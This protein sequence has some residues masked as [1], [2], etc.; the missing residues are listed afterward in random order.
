MK[1]EE[2]RKEAPVVKINE[3]LL[4]F[5]LAAIN[6]THIMDFVIMAPLG[7]LLKKEF[8]IDTRESSFLIA[9]YTLSA[10]VSGFLGTFVIDRF[11][12]RNVLLFMYAGF[13]I[14]NL[15]CAL[16]DSYHYFLIARIVAGV[17]GG[18]LGALV[19][20]IVG[21]AVPYER[22]GKATGIVMSAFSF[23]SVVGIPL[24]LFLAAK[25]QWRMPFV[26]LTAL[27][28]IVWVIAFFIMPSMTGHISGFPDV[29]D[30]K[31]E[32]NFHRISREARTILSS[33][34]GNSNLRWSL[35]F[36]VILMIAG[37]TIVPFLS[38]YTVYNVGLDQE[39]ELPWIYFFGGLATAV[40]GPIVGKMADK[41]GKQ[42]MFMISAIISIIPILI[43]TNMGKLNLSTVLIFSSM[44]FIFFGGRFVPAMSMITSGVEPRLRGSFMSINSSMMSLGSFIATF[45]AGLIIQ[46][47][48]NGELINYNY[49]GIFA[50]IATLACIAIS[51][52]IKK[53]S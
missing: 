47:G 18:V 32:N 40:S 48:P 35:L 53:V 37:L 22:R 16:T 46:N 39:K 5:I 26:M 30:R 23:A 12:R 28:A 14:S 6:F 13:T 50:C 24:G 1:M 31:G 34:F 17:F 38:D 11:D 43:V 25:I 8:H 45:G 52:K 9:V 49:V 10:G 41:Y 19:M 4:L 27:S 29:R 33:I 44:F 7:P 15:F 36:M 3:G 21:D 42:R 51:F 2:L 20:A